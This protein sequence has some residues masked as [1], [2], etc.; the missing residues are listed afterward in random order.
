MMYI[1]III[2]AQYIFDSGNIVSD[3]ATHTKTEVFDG[4]VVFCVFIINIIEKKN[5]EGR[6]RERNEIGL[7]WISFVKKKKEFSFFFFAARAVQRYT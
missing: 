4:R 6:Q 5:M 1:M 3:K 2:F 7:I